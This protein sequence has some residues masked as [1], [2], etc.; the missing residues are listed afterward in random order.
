MAKELASGSNFGEGEPQFVSVVPP[1]MRENETLPVRNV[2]LYLMWNVR[3]IREDY[4]R[5]FIGN[6][7]NQT[8]HCIATVVEVDTAA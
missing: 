1:H 7:L 8:V 4:P 2:Q 3:R 5:T 6:V